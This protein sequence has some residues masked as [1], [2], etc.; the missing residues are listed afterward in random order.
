MRGSALYL[1]GNYSADELRDVLHEKG[2]RSKTGKKI[3]HSIMV[4][5]LKN[6]F[7]AGLMVWKDQRKMGRHEPM[8]TL[9]EHHRIRQIVASHNLSVSRIRKHNFLLRGFVCCNLCGQRYT[10]ETH[11]AKRKS[12]YHCASM[13]K[14]SNRHQNV[15]VSVLERQVEEQFKTIQFSPDF[16]RSIMEKLKQVHAGQKAAAQGQKQRLFNQQKAIE[17]KRDRAEEKLLAGILS[18]DAFV[19]L[20]ARFNEQLQQ[21]QEQLATIDSQRECDT[22]VVCQDSPP[23]AQHLR[24]IQNSPS[25]PETALPGAVL[26]S[27][28]GAGSENRGSDSHGVDPSLAGGA[29]RYNKP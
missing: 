5:V 26:G 18:D 2:L 24:G 8:I 15:A 27:F 3:P 10:A 7:Y 14:H 9:E 20:R 16:I 21:I 13:R 17:A 25:C 22:E 12:Y 6:P 23:V 28:P 11:A 29:R 19:R 1:T 4:H